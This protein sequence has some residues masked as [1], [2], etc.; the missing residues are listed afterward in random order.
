M[1]DRAQH[2]GKSRQAERM[3]RQVGAKQDSLRRAHAGR[4]DFWT[5]IG[6]LGAVG[7]SVTVPSLGGIAL[8]VW[9]DRK[10]PTHFSWAV[11]LFA[12][13][14]AIGCIAAWKHLRGGHQ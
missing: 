3:L 8:G 1:A 5:S 10:W 14:L 6:L 2:D 11:T 12:A 9:L 4:N 13:G 7:W